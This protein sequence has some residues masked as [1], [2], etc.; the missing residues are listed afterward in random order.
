MELYIVRHGRTKWNELGLI[1]GSSDI[2]LLEEGREMAMKTGEALRN[3]SFDA[4]YASPLSRALETARIIIGKRNLEIR[5]EPRLREMSFGVYEGEKYLPGSDLLEGFYD[6]PDRYRAPEDGE[7]FFDICARADAFLSELLKK[8]GRDE[9]ILIVAHAAINQAL[10][11][12]LEKTELA[13][14]WKRG[15]QKNCAVAIAVSDEKGF[16]ITERNRIFYN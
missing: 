9:R 12:F 11:R 2:P 4:V 16:R 13:D 5:K 6:A 14:L 3:T 8:H 10:F 15:L 1:Q 7:S